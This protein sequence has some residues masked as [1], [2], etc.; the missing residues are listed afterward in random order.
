M[1]IPWT[2]FPLHKLLDQVEPQSSARFVRFISLD[3]PTQHPGRNDIFSFQWPYTEVHG[4]IH[5]IDA[6]L[7][8]PDMN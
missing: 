5:A 7:L 6:V 4:V 8:P 3:D 1:V 2:G